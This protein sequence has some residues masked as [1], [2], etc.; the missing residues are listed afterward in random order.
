MQNTLHYS[1][2]CPVIAWS[3]DFIHTCS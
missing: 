2:T 3:D 1:Q